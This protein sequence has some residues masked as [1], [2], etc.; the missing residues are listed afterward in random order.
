[1]EDDRRSDE[2]HRK[3]T[4]QRLLLVSSNIHLDEKLDGFQRI[5]SKDSADFG[6]KLKEMKG[7]TDIH[8]FA[9]FISPA[10]LSFPSTHIMHTAHC[11]YVSDPCAFTHN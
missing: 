5:S 1:V 4:D 11:G 7:F 9:M 3:T 10:F 8:T 2:A 6:E